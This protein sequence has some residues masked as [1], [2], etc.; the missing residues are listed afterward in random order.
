MARFSILLAKVLVATT[1]VA[2]VMAVLFNWYHSTQVLKEVDQHARETVTPVA[3]LSQYSLRTYAH[4]MRELPDSLKSASYETISESSNQNYLRHFRA[5]FSDGKY[6]S[7]IDDR[8]EPTERRLEEE[9]WQRTTQTATMDAYRKFLEEFPQSS[10]AGMARDLIAQLGWCHTFGGQQDE[11]CYSMVQTTDNGFVLCG[12]T[13]SK[14]AGE[15]DVYLLKTDIVGNLLWERTFGGPGNETAFS[16]QQTAD[17]GLV[18]CGETDSRGEGGYDIYIIKTNETGDVEWERTYGSPIYYKNEDG[19]CICQTSDE[20]YIVVGNTDLKSPFNFEAL[21]NKIDKHGSLEWQK[22]FGGP[23]DDD[24]LSVVQA[25]DG[26][27]AFVGYSKEKTSETSSHLNIYMVKTDA[28]GRLEWERELG[29]GIGHSIQLLE[30]GGFLIAGCIEAGNDGEYKACII[31][32]DERGKVLWSKTFATD[33]ANFACQ[34]KNRG[35]I[36]TGYTTFLGSDSADVFL[37]KLTSDGETEWQRTFGGPESDYGYCVIQARL[38]NF[39]ITGETFSNGSDYSDVF[40]GAADE[41]GQ[42]DWVLKDSI[43]PANRQDSESLSDFSEN[44][45]DQGSAIDADS[46]ETAKRGILEFA[47][48]KQYGPSV[49]M[50]DYNSA[51][52]EITGT[53][54]QEHSDENAFFR[55][56]GIGDPDH[57][58]R[59]EASVI[60]R[61]SREHGASGWAS[62]WG[63]VEYSEL[64]IQMESWY[65]TLV[66]EASDWCK[67]RFQQSERTFSHFIYIKDDDL[68]VS[69]YAFF[70][71]DPNCCPR[72]SGTLTYEFTNSGLL[73]LV[74]E[75]IVRKE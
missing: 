28:S 27:F 69:V 43:Q 68:E 60:W 4:D 34:T 45:R 29:R 41:Y 54:R 36:L 26:G 59:L 25:A 46:L 52:D 13:E 44:P 72:Y 75:D 23:Y 53:Y 33:C 10:H 3:Y 1:I 18:V 11:V 17:G 49:R 63:I 67:R 70:G 6:A 5:G 14:G 66:M 64:S 15:K 62:E 50:G 47:W 37:L 55:L 56:I 61:S 32:T 21:L 2:V 38:G 12:Y 71:D 30:D 24:G 42:I 9:V 20:G 22:T 57:D 40:I 16:V 65:K 7:A 74:N 8:I 35:F 58:G 19:N 51:E 48:K 31:K 73:K 39:I